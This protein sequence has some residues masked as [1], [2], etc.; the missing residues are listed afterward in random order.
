MIIGDKVCL[1]PMFNADAGVVFNWHNTVE[2]MR[3]D[4]MYRPVSEGNFDKWFGTI[5]QEPSRIVFAIRNKGDLRF[6]GYVQI[7]NIHPVNRS[8]EI[9]IMIGVAADRGQGRGKE[10]LR[11]CID[12]CWTELNLQRLTMMVVGDNAQALSA[13]KKVG[14]EQEGVLRNAVYMNGS[15]RDATILG[16]LR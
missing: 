6:L 4:G 8:A 13:Y 15:F 11:L 14:F 3:L 1:G 7:T 12:F 9:G 16:L 10:A 5:G 2:L